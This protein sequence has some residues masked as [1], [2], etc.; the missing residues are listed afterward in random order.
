MRT[1]KAFDI[2]IG[3]LII[4]I[5]TRW[6]LQLHVANV[7]ASFDDDPPMQMN[8]ETKIGLARVLTPDT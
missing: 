8:L 1:Y 6:S 7:I 2:N 5:R 4:L 3:K